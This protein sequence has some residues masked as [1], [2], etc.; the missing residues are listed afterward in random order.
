[1]STRVDY[2]ELL[3]VTRES[4][5]EEIK[6]AYRRLAV[7][8]HPDKNQGDKTAEEKFKE[9]GHAY[10][11]L[12]DDQ[13]RAAYDRFG[14]AAF[15]GGGG[16]AGGGTGGFH[17]PMDV[18]REMFRGS[19]FED[20]FGQSGQQRGGDLRYDLEITLEEAA[21]GVEKEIKYRRAAQCDACNGT[22]AEPGSKRQTCPTCRGHGQVI[23]QRGFFSVRQAC[24]SCHGQGTLIERPCAKC[25]GA[26]R[27]EETTKLKVR[28]PPGVDS[29]Q[30]LR[31]NAGGEAGGPGVATGDLYIFLHVREH[32]LF[33]RDG[34]DLHTTIPIKFTLASLGGT[35]D[36]PTLTGK[37]QL[38]I[39]AGTQSGTLLRLRGRGMPSL[40]GSE[41][42]D[43]YV[44]VEIEVPKKLSNEQKEK[45]EEFGRA[46]GDAE[47]PTSESF[48]QK[49]KR[50]FEM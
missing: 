5:G 36:V 23:S 42:G 6:K 50:F 4:S 13:K 18:F 47:R 24:P 35:L 16:G 8:Y 46:C 45:L 9:I 31:S 30:K 2:Y 38:K 27:V 1:M 10:E 21:A 7:K 3:E 15:Q 32:E 44:H 48:F 33:Q 28:V 17:D 43:Q 22:G 29:G 12:S 25:R 49:A 20:M 11:V 19:G 14:H 26:G 34:D 39:P 41:H 40:R 37:A